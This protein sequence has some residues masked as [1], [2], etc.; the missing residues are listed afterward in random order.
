MTE[1][2]ELSSQGSLSC[3]S[4]CGGKRFKT[5]TAYSTSSKPG[6]Y[7]ACYPSHKAAHDGCALLL[8]RMLWFHSASIER[9]FRAAEAVQQRSSERRKR[10]QEA[11]RT[12]SLASASENTSWSASGERLMHP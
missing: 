10:E 2:G 9:A 3:T 8:E 7:I 6:W 12:P 5:L 1:T 4:S 11:S